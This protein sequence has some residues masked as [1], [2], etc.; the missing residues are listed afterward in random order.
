M[1]SR[2]VRDLTMIG[3]EWFSLNTGLKIP[4]EK[5]QNLV[6]QVKLFR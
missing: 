4:E 1:V 2:L 3:K 5:K 6:N